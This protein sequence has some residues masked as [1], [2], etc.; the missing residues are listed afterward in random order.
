MTNYD[1]LVRARKLCRTC[2]S[3]P[4]GRGQSSKRLMNGMER[5]YDPDVVS[6]WSQWLGD[7]N[8]RLQIVGQDFSNTDYFRRH[9]GRDAPEIDTNKNLF[10]LLTEEACIS[11]GPPPISDPDSAIYLTNSILCLKEGEMKASVS[12]RWIDACSD[13]HLGPLMAL[14]RPVAVVGMGS[15]GWRAVRRRFMLDH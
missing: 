10:R 5:G 12:P 8:R 14:L 9:G 7:R 1:D 2:M 13:S 15:S 6:H 4:S 3:S 11:V